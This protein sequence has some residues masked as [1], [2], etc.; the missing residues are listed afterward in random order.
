MPRI[1]SRTLALVAVT[2]CVLIAL[3]VWRPAHA[4]GPGGPALA[5]HEQSRRGSAP[6]APPGA[7]AGQTAG[8]AQRDA[9]R[10]RGGGR[11]EPGAARRDLSADEAR[12]GH[13]LSRHVGLTDADL[14]DRL[15][16]EPRIA[17][18]STYTDRATA[19]RTVAQ[20]LA[21]S[22]RRLDSWQRRDGRRPNLALDYR[23][24]PSSPVGRS[25][26]RDARQAQPCADAVVVLRWD[27][28]AGDCYVLTSYPECRP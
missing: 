13:T 14:R 25:M 8:T 18:A 22:A 2:A 16:R 4:P 5:P 28:R 3:L 27:E 7:S 15:R 21:Q 11:I 9:A 12:G 6:L 1:P 26:R 17:A 19:E 24:V 10:E 20:A 23:G